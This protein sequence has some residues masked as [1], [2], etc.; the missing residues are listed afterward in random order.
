[1]KTGIVI[2]NYNDVANTLKMVQQISSYQTLSKIVVVDNCSTESILELRALESEKVVLLEA[3]ENL[4]Y[5]A[6]NNI[7]L[8]YLE[9]LCDLVFISNP[10][11]L[12][13]ESAI[14]GMIATMQKNNISFLGPSIKECGK[15]IRGWK[16]PSYWVEVLSTIN[17]WGRYARRLQCYKDDYYKEDIVPVEVIHGCFF[18]ARMKDFKKLEYF[19][20]NT[21][22][23]YEEN[24]IGKKAKNMGQ[25]IYVCTTHFVTHALSLSVDKSLKKIKKYKILKKSMFYYEKQYNHRSFLALFFLR[26]VYSISLVVSY[27][28]FFL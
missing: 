28:T 27:L 20:E 12:V 22:L 23:Y 15:I 16:L 13:S 19:D 9:G 18:L 26:L 25:V 3:K 17:F 7:G 6:G 10:D 24:I 4:G 14:E 21:F 2:L 1:M 8:R 11:I 5:G